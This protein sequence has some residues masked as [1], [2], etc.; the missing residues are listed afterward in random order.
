[1]DKQTALRELEVLSATNEVIIRSETP[2]EAMQRLCQAALEHGEFLGVAVLMIGSDGGLAYVAGAGEGVEVMKDVK[3]SV[4]PES[5]HGQGLAG[6]AFRS[7]VASFSNDYMADPRMRPWRDVGKRYGVASAAAIPILDQDESHGVL[8][9]Y[10][11]R[12][13]GMTDELLALMQRV[14]DNIAFAFRSFRRHKVRLR[15]KRAAERLARLYGAL[16]ETNEALL[17]AR[18]PDEMFKRICEA[19]ASGG[20]P[21]GAAAVFLA[22]PGSEWLKFKAGAGN[23]IGLIKQTLLSLDPGSR[24]GGGLHGPAFREGKPYISYDISTDARVAPWRIAGVPA[25]GCAVLPLRKGG[26]CVGILT[27]YFGRSTGAQRAE[28]ESLMNRIADNVSFALDMFESEARLLKS[29]RMFAAL[30]ATNEAIFR[31]R[32]V[33]EMLQLVCDASVKAGHY[34]S[35]AI[36][37]IEEGSTDL[38]LAASSGAFTEVVGQ[39]RVSSDPDQPHGKGLAGPALRTGELS[40]SN[41][42]INDPRL[43]FVRPLAELAGVRC[44]AALP[45]ARD[46]AVVG[47][48]HFFFG[49]D[50]GEIDEA[51]LGLL[52]RLGENVSFGLDSFDREKKQIRLTRMFAALSAT[53]EAIMRATTRDE[54]FRMVCA[55][56][57]EGAKFSSTTVFLPQA[58]NHFLKIAAS[59]GPNEPF[60]MR[61]KYSS[62]ADRAEGRGLV[63]TAFRSGRPAVANE[64]QRD[65]RTLNWHALTRKS[66]AQS[67]A[68]L[69]LL[70]HGKTIGVLLFMSLEINVFTPELINL[71]QRLAENVAFALENF[72]R[73]DESRLAEE[74]IRYLASHDNLT[75][76]PNRVSFS[77]ALSEAIAEADKRAQ[78][79]A[80]LFIDLDRFKII[81]DSLGHAAGD[82]LL[83]EMGRRLREA[84]PAGAM[85]ARLGGD[86]FVVMLRHSAAVGDVAGIARV[87]LHALS[88]PMTIGAQECLTTASIGIAMFP[89]DGR[90]EG[91]LTK[92]ADVAMY[93][94]KE[95]G[96]NAFRFYTG[97]RVR[98]SV[99][100]LKLETQL[101]HALLRRE[102]ELHYQPKVTTDTQQITGVEGLLRWT[103]PELGSVSPAKF[104]PIA[105][106]TGLIIP[107][108]RWVLQTACHQA[109]A[110][111]M[112]GL[113]PLSVAVNLSPR[114]FLDSGLLETLD[115]ALTASGL[116]PNLLQLEITESMV[117][118]NVEQAVALLDK[119]QARGV[120]LA[121]D[122]F[123]TGYSSMSMMK[124]FPIDT[125]KIDRS[126]V[127]DLPAD[128]DDR[129]I[130]EAIIHM[131]KA[132][133]LTVVAEGVENEAQ[134]AFLAARACDQIQGFL[135]SRPVPADEIP[136]LLTIDVASAPPLQPA[137]PPE[138]VGR[139]K[140]RRR[141]R[142]R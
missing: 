126:F 5:V 44:A 38:K 60:I 140:R 93:E 121:I 128:R 6:L 131:G 7:K 136:K 74:R 97:M 33:E 92:C 62:R 105:E 125:I 43:T 36:S 141:A 41:D 130:A 59:A 9:L 12:I 103:H 96:K 56:S 58:D 29:E 8:L 47:V 22:E 10:G 106:E 90:D 68:A 4:D 34:L 109:V 120:T 119:I 30:S 114:Q 39:M 67:G 50:I 26:T 18:T 17:R 123:G 14:S 52:K 102:F 100:R 84:A 32:S 70:S 78:E 139:P 107:I 110:W 82:S 129:A 21:L 55:A 137:P 115:D 135:F 16:G 27:F 11:S 91:A 73:A 69:P 95:E 24:F 138:A 99:E 81:N 49:N 75:G 48:M 3:I 111:Q 116:S 89:K 118:L 113:P 54:L 108:G 83:V 20:E 77:A 134:M 51:M 101:R 132:L 71:L 127:R 85:V 98:P 122:D 61:L 42:V 80:V 13:G 19:A 112:Q 65:A 79:L 142:S 104:I 1:M 66:G 53:N 40:F 72:D 23:N 45:L 88:R 94:A 37:L 46:G 124:R 57:V 117:M 86:E 15:Q 31:A 76:L 28:I 64:Y 63:G 133:G 87:V 25:F 35:V 2:T